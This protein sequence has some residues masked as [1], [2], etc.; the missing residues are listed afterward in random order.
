MFALAP[1]PAKR[2]GLA[3]LALSAGAV[4]LAAAA[5]LTGDR[6]ILTAAVLSGL[7]GAGTYV[8]SMAALLRKRMRKRLGPEFLLL[9]VGWSFLPLSITAAVVLAFGYLPG[10][11]P[12]LFGVTLLVGW[13]L[14]FVMG[15]LQRIV[16]F[17]ASMHASR[18]KGPPPLVSALTPTGPARIHVACHL[19]ALALLLTGIVLD[20][21]WIVRA[22][23]LTGLFGSLAFAVFFA[24]VLWR[25]RG[26]RMASAGA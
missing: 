4:A 10:K 8:G 19:A 15:I 21:G 12:A 13:L 11:A 9:R 18:G 1:A 2:T 3:A 5:A 17:L 16:P 22:G 25:L 23:A 24:G 20:S 26:L 6:L 7:A 14:S